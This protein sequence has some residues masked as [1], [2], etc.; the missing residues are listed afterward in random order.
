MSG[1]HAFPCTVTL[2][3]RELASGGMARPEV[4]SAIIDY[5]QPARPIAAVQF[6]GFDAKV[7]FEKEVHKREVMECEHIRI[8]DVDCAVRG[9]GPRPQNVLIYNFPFEVSHALIHNSLSLYGM[10]NPSS[11]VIGHI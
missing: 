4:V 10:F 1:R 11:S 5:F 2:N 6:L 7:T 8:R 9:G 3:V